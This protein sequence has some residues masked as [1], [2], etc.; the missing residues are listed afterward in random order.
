[1]ILRGPAQYGMAFLHTETDDNDLTYFL[2][3]HLEIIQKAIDGLFRYVR[4]RG[5]E[6]QS[7]D[8]TLRGMAD[9]NHRQRDL[10][11]HA[12]RHP[13]FAYTIKTHRASHGIVYQTART[14]LM[15]LEKRG[16]DGQAKARQGLVF[17]PVQNLEE[18]LRLDE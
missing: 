6:L 11:Q 14:D 3:Y 9:L 15:D 7:L 18:K 8:A 10:I 12:L 1:M 5:Q 2:I 13:G 4:R 16:P 17:L